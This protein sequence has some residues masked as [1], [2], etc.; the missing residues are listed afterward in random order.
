VSWHQLQAKPKT[1]QDKENAVLVPIGY[2]DK[3]VQIPFEE[4]GTLQMLFNMETAYR[5]DQK[6]LQITG[7]KIATYDAGKPDIR[8]DMPV[9]LYEIDTDTISSTD[10]VTIHRSDFQITGT[11]MTFNTQTHKGKFRGP[12]RM[13]IFNSDTF[14]QGAPQSDAPVPAP[15]SGGTAR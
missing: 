13:V 1:S 15:T 2:A 10:P 7:L 4:N 3:G 12:A 5:V 6:Q 14:A 8:I 9:A 11:H